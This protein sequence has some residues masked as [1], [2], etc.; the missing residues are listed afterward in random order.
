MYPSDMY[1]TNG[2]WIAISYNSGAGVSF[3]NSSSR[4]STIE[5]IRGNGAHD[6][7]FTY[8]SDSI[9]HLTGITNTIGTAE[10]YT[11][12][13]ATGALTAPF[14]PAT[15]YGT[16]TF[17]S[18]IANNI[19]LTTSFTYDS[20]GS[21]ELDKVTFPYGGYIRWAHG[22][23]TYSN[24]RT[25]R[26]VNGGRFLAMSAGATELSYGIAFQSTAGN[27][28]HTFSQVDD[29]DGQSE[30]AW[31]FDS[32]ATDPG[33]GLVSYMESRPRHYPNVAGEATSSP[34]WTL[35]AA[36]NPYLS[37]VYAVTDAG[38][39]TALAKK[40]LQTVDQYGNVTQMQTYGFGPVNRSLPLLRTYT[41][42][43]LGT[44]AY[45]SRYTTTACSP[46]R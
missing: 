39:P 8:N 35:D 41:N 37:Q 13:Y 25:Y 27:T 34:T 15:S 45:T 17:L 22:P 28:S 32:T 24:G 18:S 14:T 12:H 42:T 31:A 19:P 36:S 21:G 44:S 9:P 7:S 16:W 4:I 11:F 20:A 43:Y 29:P 5:D 38:N 6:Y 40:T 33:F 30:K 26:E 23:F 10:N 1:D 3:A 46:A 2:N